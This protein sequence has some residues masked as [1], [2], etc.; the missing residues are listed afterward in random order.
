MTQKVN[1]TI[2]WLKN[3]LKVKISKKKKKIKLNLNTRYNLRKTNTEDDWRSRYW[4]RNVILAPWSTL[5]KK[6]GG[7][8]KMKEK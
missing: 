2:I 6:K 8:K 4:G 5:K 1:A 7:N 3:I